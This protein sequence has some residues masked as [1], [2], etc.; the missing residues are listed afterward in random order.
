MATGC[1]FALRHPLA[2]HFT[3]QRSRKQF[4]TY[5]ESDTTTTGPC[6]ANVRTACRA[7][8][9]SI[10]WFVVSGSPPAPDGVPSGATAQAQPPGPGFP[11]QAPSV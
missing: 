6:G 4:T 7:A 11:A 8:V 9:I 10:R 1:F 3:Y 2:S 5:V